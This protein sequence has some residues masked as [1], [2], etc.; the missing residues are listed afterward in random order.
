MFKIFDI[1][2][3]TYVRI[4]SHFLQNLPSRKEQGINF[5]ILSILQQEQEQRELKDSITEA[6]KSTGISRHNNRVTTLA[7]RN[8]GD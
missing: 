6:K 7:K 2:L 8:I 3:N 5:E 1:L 4:I